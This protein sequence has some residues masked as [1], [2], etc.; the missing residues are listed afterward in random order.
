VSVGKNLHRLRHLS[1]YPGCDNWDS[2]GAYWGHAMKLQRRQFLH[3]AA[4]AVALPAV[5]RLA[6]AQ[7]Y[8]SRPVR[9]IVGFT[10]GGGSDILARLTGQELSQRLGQPFVV[11]NRTGAGS[12]IAAEIV[13]NAPADG[14][15][16][17]L[18]TTANAVNATLYDKLNF[19]FIRDIAPVAGLLRVPNVMLVN[20][21][22]PAETVPEFIA[23]AKAN[24][25]KVNMGSGGNGGPV[26][27]AGELFKMMAGVNL[28]HVPY[29]GEALALTDLLGGQVQV[30][31]GSIPSS[32]GYIRG[33]QLRPLAVTTLTRSETLPDVPA[34]A[35][36]VPG[37][38]MST[39]YGIG[40][41]KDTPTEV[42]DKLNIGIN[43]VLADPG[44]KARLADLSGTVLGGSPAALGS[45]I[46]EETQ[47]WAKV[48][49]FA[50]M[51]PI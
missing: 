21:A 19:N 26:H 13:V 4:G 39:W 31:F 11:E 45:L 47:K 30:V 37:Y 3:L 42:I 48:V 40:S 8:P 50:G 14:H 17:L 18:A 2:F 15:T 22:V 27:M 49:K 34:M 20:P 32:I 24:P 10:A 16:L 5:S 25:T 6:Q 23:Y 35:D 7:T 44:F 9:L 46:A 28:V 36:F 33:N 51:T 43:A 12:N 29:R 41:P 1:L 38:E